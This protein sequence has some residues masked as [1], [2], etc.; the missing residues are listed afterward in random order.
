[1]QTMIMQMVQ[2]MAQMQELKDTF[3]RQMKHMREH[4]RSLT[5][6]MQSKIDNMDAELSRLA[7]RM[8]SDFPTK[9]K[10]RGSSLDASL[11]YSSTLTAEQIDADRS[12]MIDQ[13]Q[14]AKPLKPLQKPILQ[15][16]AQQH[17]NIISLSMLKDFESYYL[18][19]MDALIGYEHVYQYRPSD[20]AT[21][22]SSIACSSPG[23]T[24]SFTAK[25]SS[26]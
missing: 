4:N 11:D 20:L 14:C 6:E 12:R 16:M 3:C 24:R 1:M 13:E 25:L 15:P 17:S 19:A 26:G 2:R 8:S 7:T 23:Y 10:P 9:A 21:P 5:G 22:G 18:N